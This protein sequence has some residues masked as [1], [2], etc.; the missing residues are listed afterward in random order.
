VGEI[1]DMLKNEDGMSYNEKKKYW[2]RL[3]K[4][5]E[6]IDKKHQEILDT[7][8]EKLDEQS[9]EIPL[10][11]EADNILNELRIEMETYMGDKKQKVEVEEILDKNK[12][13]YYMNLMEKLNKMKLPE[14]K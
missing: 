6:L 8:I 1:N 12:Q 9:F 11:K 3:Y 2:D 4:G 13:L 10:D 5:T 14:K 7:P